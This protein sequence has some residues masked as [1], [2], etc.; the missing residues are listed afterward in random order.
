MNIEALK[1]Q[2]KQPEVPKQKSFDFEKLSFKSLIEEV[3]DKVEYTNLINNIYTAMDKDP[4][5]LNPKD[6]NPHR[7][8]LDSIVDSYQGVLNVK[9]GD[10]NED[11]LKFVTDLTPETHETLVMESKNFGALYDSF[12]AFI[13]KVKEI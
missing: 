8:T 4:D 13:E 10:L 11:T 9:V 12:H 3:V 2:K 1:A 6:L 7:N 5:S